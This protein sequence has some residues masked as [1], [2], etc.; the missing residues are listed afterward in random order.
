[1]GFFK[2]GA[3]IERT[4]STATA[5]GTTT[6][7]NT[8]TTFQRFTG[9]TTQTV[10]LPDATTLS[11]GQKFVIQNRSTGAVTIQDGTA[12]LLTTLAAG[13]DMNLQI[14]SIGSTAGT[15]D[16]SNPYTTSGGGGGS[17]A[18]FSSTT[19][20]NPSTQSPYAMSSSSNQGTVFEVNT[21]NGAQ[22]FN[23]PALLA[24][25]IFTVTDVALDADVNNITI[26]RA[27]SEQIAGVAADYVIAAPGS[28]TTFLCDGTNYII[29]A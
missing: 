28:S 15:W 4:T 12:T 21:A 9:T 5:A 22:T 6:L 17:G 14:Y 16:T 1:M 13:L 26:H 25:F 2:R 19:A 20:I 18:A 23:L 8:S 7:V 27:G 10:V 24:G 11:L 3:L 29:V